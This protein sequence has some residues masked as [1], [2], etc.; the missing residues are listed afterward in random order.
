MNMTEPLTTVLDSEYRGTENDHQSL[1]LWLRLLTCATMVENQL[2]ARLRNEFNSTLP[3]FDMLAQL[4]KHPEG[5]NMGQLSQMMMVSGGN[6]T[7][8]SNQLE[9]E[10]LIKREVSPGDRRSFVVKLTPKGTKLFNKMSAAHEAWIIELFGELEPE[11]NAEL[12]A[13]LKKVKQSILQSLKS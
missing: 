6:V 13:R 8:I 11:D 2:R 10:E 12:M 3:R 5:L 9:K 7:G 1:R 4:Q